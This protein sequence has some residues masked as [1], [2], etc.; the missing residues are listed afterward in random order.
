MTFRVLVLSGGSLCGIISL[1]VLKKIEELSGQPIHKFF[2]LII[3]SSTGTIEGAVLAAGGTPSEIE[4][5]YFANGEHIFTYQ[6]PW[7]RPIKKITSPWYSRDRVLNP[8]QSILNKYGASVMKNLKTKFVAVTVNTLVDENIRMRS[9]GGD[10]YENDPIVNCVAKSFAAVAYF[11]HY[12]DEKRKMICE[13]GGEGLAN[14]PIMYGLVEALKLATREDTIEIYAVGAGYTNDCPS[15]EAAKGQNNVENLW[16]SYLA[17]G[18]TLAR[19]QARIEQV[20]LLHEIA[21]EI[22]NIKFAYFDTKISKDSNTM[23]G[24]KYMNYYKEMGSKIPVKLI[25]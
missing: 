24:W 18:E 13:D 8:L 11:G 22:P 23:T 4:D 10:E 5:M 15:F 16:D 21:K 19:I 17:E 25:S 2:D 9:F 20:K 3:G 7:W 12:V 14:L 1:E 6:Y